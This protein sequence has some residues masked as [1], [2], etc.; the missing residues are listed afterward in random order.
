MVTTNTAPEAAPGADWIKEDWR[1]I[2]TAIWLGLFTAIEVFTY[3]ESVH[4][5]P[6]TLLIIL[7]SVLM[8]VKF[9]IVGAVFMHLA[10][11]HPVF[12]R[13]MVLG[14]CIAW[15][16]FGVAAYATGWLDWNLYIKIAFL[17]VPPI[18]T[19][20]ALGYTFQGGDGGHDH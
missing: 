1:Y 10:D 4:N 20:W 6:K 19:G 11:D 7:L 14:L 2:K 5:M 17:A 13:V 15:P 8:T 16:V 18:I 12:T 3:F 9:V